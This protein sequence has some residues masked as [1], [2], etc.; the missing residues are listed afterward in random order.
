MVICLFLNLF[1]ICLN[2]DWFVRMFCI[3]L[4]RELYYFGCGFLLD[5][6]IYFCIMIE[7]V[8]FF[9]IIFI[10]KFSFVWRMF[11]YLNYMNFF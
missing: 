11:V 10:K 6:E 1:E 2:I 3:D 7:I 9:K 5:Y 4:L 8:G